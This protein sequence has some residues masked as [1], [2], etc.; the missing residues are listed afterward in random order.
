MSRPQPLCACR[1]YIIANLRW[2]SIGVAISTH[3]QDRRYVTRKSLSTVTIWSKRRMQ[4]NAE[5]LS[6]KSIN[7]VHAVGTTS[8]VACA[9]DTERNRY[10]S[11]APF[12]D[13]RVTST[14]SMRSTERKNVRRYAHPCGLPT[15]LVNAFNAYHR[16]KHCRMLC[17]RNDPELQTSV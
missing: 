6:T 17:E 2:C 13:P 1:D 10:I 14:C 8:R 15:H 16:T 12:D 11:F 3:G 4:R 5:R 9:T 7:V